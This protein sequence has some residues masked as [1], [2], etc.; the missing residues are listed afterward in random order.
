MSETEP[1][2]SQ[3][4][5]A[6]VLGTFVLVFF[7][8]GAAVTTGGQNLVAIALAFGISVLVMVY[9]VGHISGGHFNPAVSV[10]AAIAGRLSWVQAGMYAA[11]QLVGAVVAATVVFGVMHGFD[12]FDAGS[13]GM[14]QNYFGDQNP[15]ADYALWAALIVE[16][17]ATAVFL[18]VI[19]AATDKRNPSAAAAPAAI[20][21]ALTGIHLVLI[22]LTGTSVNP[23]RSIAPALFAGSDAIMQLWLFIVAPLIGAA[24]AGST[25]ALIFGSDGHAV[26]GSGLNFGSGSAAATGFAGG[27][28]PNAPQGHQL[29]QPWG[30]PVA[31]PG[32][33]PWGQPAPNA[34]QQPWGAPEQ[35]AQDPNQWGHPQQ[36]PAQDPNQ[37]GQHQPPLE[38]GPRTQIRPPV[39]P[40]QP[41]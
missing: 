39:N 17:V 24:I 23:A 19:L 41:N 40:D 8:V 3:K 35:P 28:N 18:Y 2:L 13:D 36:P 12:G 11:A 27:W 34:G 4:L 10:G 26:P 20:G 16:I 14:G 38:D 33:Q 7:G 25:Y 9:A 29:N 21:L 22:P 32:Q 31:D 15:N 1:A 6:E 30:Q 5:G 37:W